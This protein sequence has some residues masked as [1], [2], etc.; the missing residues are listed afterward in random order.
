MLIDKRIIEDIHNGH[1]INDDE[2]EAAIVFYRDLIE[3]LEC[4]GEI[5]AGERSSRQRTLNKLEKI[6]SD[7]K[8]WI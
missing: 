5:Y 8:L 1:H 4:L 6:A 7:R 3:S 2:L